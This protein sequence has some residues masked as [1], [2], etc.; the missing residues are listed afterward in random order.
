MI[1]SIIVAI[2]NRRAGL[3][4]DWMGVKEDVMLRRRLIVVSEL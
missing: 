2:K 4:K 1:P 3:L